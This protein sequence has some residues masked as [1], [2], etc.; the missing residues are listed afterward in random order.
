MA[1]SGMSLIKQ[2][3]SCLTIDDSFRPKS[4]SAN[5]SFWGKSWAGKEGDG[6][7]RLALAREELA[8]AEKTSAGSLSGSVCMGDGA[9]RPLRSAE[10]RLPPHHKYRRCPDS[11]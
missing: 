9:P 7:L 1:P 4:F 11:E 6:A 2:M 3:L 10:R 8:R 5:Y